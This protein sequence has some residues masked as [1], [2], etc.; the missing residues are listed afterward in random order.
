MTLLLI[1]P[2][3]CKANIG[4]KKTGRNAHMDAMYV[5]NPILV[6]VDPRRDIFSP[7][8]SLLLLLLLFSSPLFINPSSIIVADDD[9]YNW[10][11]LGKQFEI[12]R[13]RPCCC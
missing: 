7:P 13:R 3:R 5:N 10:K 12:V 8:L 1:I 2:N 9:E 6:R 11:L 4:S